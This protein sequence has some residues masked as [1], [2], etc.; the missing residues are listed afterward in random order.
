MHTTTTPTREHL[1]HD[2]DQV[3][4]AISEEEYRYKRYDIPFCLL[5]INT[6]NSSHYDLLENYVRKTDI[7]IPL[8]ENYACIVLASTEIADA[9][10]MGEN[11]IRDHATLDQHN[12][13]FM[14]VTSVRNEES[15]YDIVSRAFYTLDKA[16]ENNISVVEDDN[17][18]ERLI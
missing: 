8:S 10:K 4:K 18:L 15:N 14:G 16:R 3:K 6:E 17:I 2:K 7:V 11:F 13:I 9:I 5:A 12:R 1:L